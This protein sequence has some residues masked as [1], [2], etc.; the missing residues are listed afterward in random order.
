MPWPNCGIRAAIPLVL[1]LFSCALRGQ[2]AQHPDELALKPQ[3]DQAIDRGVQYLIE[4]QFRD[5]SWGVH[6]EFLGGRTGLCLYTLLQCGVPREHSVVQRAVARLDA[7]EPE[8]TYATACMILAYDALRDGREDRIESWVKKLV[9]WQT[10]RGDWGYPQRHPDLSNTQYAALGLWVATKRGI[11]VD[12][13]CFMALLD[14]LEDY[15]EEPRMVDDPDAVAGRTGVGKVE[16]AG[17]RYRPEN[18]QKV[19]GSMTSAGIAVLAICK[20]G[21]GKRLTSAVRRRIER[22]QDGAVRWFA[23]NF[24]A[25]RNPNGAHHL[26]YLYGVERVGALLQTEQFGAHWWYVEGAQ[27]LLKTQRDG[28]W[29]NVNDTCFALL[30]L[31]RATNSRAATTGVSGTTEHVFSAG[32]ADADIRLRGAGQAPV[33]LWIDGFG[34]GLRRRY[35]EYGLRVVGVEYV[36]D[37]GN[38][39]GR[40][41][42]DP[43]KAWQDQTFLHREKAMERGAHRVRARVTLIGRD[44][45]PEQEGAVD[46][47]ESDWMDVRIRDVVAPWMVT[48]NDAFRENVLRELEP[49]ATASSELDK[50]NGGAN[51]FDGSDGTRWIAALDDPQPSVRIEWDKPARVASVLVMLPAQHE[52]N[53]NEFDHVDGVEVLLGDDRDEWQRLPVGRDPVAPLALELDR[54][55]RLRAIE[56][57]FYGRKQREGAGAKKGAGRIGLAEVILLAKSKG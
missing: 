26:Y 51:L 22:L 14:R 39:L 2:A 13:A 54:P 16:V 36:D 38:V 32:G 15:R 57:R 45:A 37:R 5:G 1:T 27:Q 31:R 12:P 10:P 25:A 6:G 19:T 55:R 52:N 3:I 20:A 35:A 47:V 40:I 56:L 17:F 23:L 4:Q 53:L 30:F 34:E 44:V 18:N 7:I 28:A 49:R 48:A 43:T 41:A 46:V 42:G 24:T 21:L 33:S 9:D 29:G 11:K 50:N 8:T